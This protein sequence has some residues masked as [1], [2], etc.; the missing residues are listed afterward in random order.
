MSESKHDQEKYFPGKGCTCG[1]WHGH[2]CGC[3]AV[4]TPVEVIELRKER[5]RLIKL[6]EDH[7]ADMAALR[8]NDALL[9]F[10]VPEDWM[11]EI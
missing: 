9:G 7:N 2:E 1:A 11:I 3:T 8:D 6:I 5:D 10:I 4:W